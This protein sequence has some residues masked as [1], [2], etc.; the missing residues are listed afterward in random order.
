MYLYVS[1][2]SSSFSSVN[3]ESL[4]IIFM[5]GGEGCGIGDIVGVNYRGRMSFI[6]R[7]LATEVKRNRGETW[8]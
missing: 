4:L 8:K 3:H 6:R 7:F 5:G 1:P 2:D